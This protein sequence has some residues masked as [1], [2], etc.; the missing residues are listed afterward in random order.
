MLQHA[1]S[2]ALSS[3]HQVQL[4]ETIPESDTINDADVVIVDAAALRER[5][6]LHAN[7]LLAVQGWKT[8]TL[9]ID[10]ESPF[11][12]P[13]RKTLLPFNQVIAKDALQR[14]LAECLG[15]ITAAKQ[16]ANPRVSEAS[17][18]VKANAKEHDNQEG[19]ADKTVIELVDVVE[20]GTARGKS[21]APQK[22]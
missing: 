20:E 22:K 17:A 11:Q 13:A 5:N 2:A 18:F 1:F 4:T 19:D 6:S 10:S 3:E 12:A 8:P 9:W 15:A 21:P 16:P 7:E 14:A